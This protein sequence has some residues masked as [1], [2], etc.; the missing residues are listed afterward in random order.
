MADAKSTLNHQMTRKESLIQLL[1]VLIAVVIIYSFTN[2]PRTIENAASRKDL[3]SQ[4]DPTGATGPQGIQG[5]MG[6][7][8][9]VGAQGII[10]SKGAA[11]TAGS[12][13]A[14]GSNG[15]IGANGTNGSNGANGISG[16]NGINGA[17]GT[18][19]SDFASY[20]TQNAFSPEPLPGN[21]S[22]NTQNTRVG[23][24]ISVS[25]STITISAPGTYYL[26][27]EGTVESY[28]NEGI[29]ALTDFAVRLMKQEQGGS[30]TAVGADP[31]A[32]YNSL[33][34]DDNNGGILAKTEYN[35]AQ[36][37]TVTNA[38]AVL[39]VNL[40]SLQGSLYH[41]DPSLNIFQIK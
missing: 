39:R 20:Y 10:G 15:A 38:P 23:T 19:S 7:T 16:T 6:L 27:A 12:T 26:S 30:N 34:H 2:R 13:G 41:S 1:L 32:Q 17:D 31:F 11:G 33:Y 36:I 9:A 28:K 24:H 21:V 14:N 25:G 40:N 37:V 18:L 35:I 3:A 8:G 29:D 5:I 4:A 22:Y